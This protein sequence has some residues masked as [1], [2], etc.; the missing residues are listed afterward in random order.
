[1]ADS[2]KRHFRMIE[3][4]HRRA[5]M[6]IIV[7]LVALCLPLV[8]EGATINM[9]LS[10]MDVQY[11]G[12]AS[13]NTGSIYDTIGQ[14]GGNLNAAEA[15]EIEAAVFE[16]DMTHIGTLTSSAGN[17]LSGDLR[18]NGVGASLPLN[19]LRTNIGSNGGG[20]GFDWFTQS[21]NNLRLGI[22]SLDNLLITNNVFFF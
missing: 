3:L 6:R 14:P 2:L 10:D 13:G 11:N 18:I 9:I 12:E 22:N 19:S 8:A 4:I 16:V 1:M 5:S 17:M 15:D 21:G 7:A 20:F